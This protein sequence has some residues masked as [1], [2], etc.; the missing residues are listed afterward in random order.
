MFVQVS[1]TTE[2]VDDGSAAAFLQLNGQMM[3]NIL[4]KTSVERRGLL[5]KYGTIF[6]SKILRSTSCKHSLS[7]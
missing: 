2:L 7:L 3:S 4:D 6:L 1:N 5:S